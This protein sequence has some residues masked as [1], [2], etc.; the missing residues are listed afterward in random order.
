M[1]PEGRLAYQERELLK[2][3]ISFRG[4]RM[5]RSFHPTTIEVTTEDYLTENGD[6]IIGV[7]ASKGCS[8]LDPG[9]KAGLRTAGA[10]VTFRLIVGETNFEFFG[11]GDPRLGLSHPHDLVIRKSEFISDRTVAV[12]A[13]AAARD[14]PRT[15][16]KLLQNPEARGLMEIEI[17]G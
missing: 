6:C 2:D 1:E 11:R 13:N 5:V 9:V 16:V 10:K 7:G 14:I 3:V 4:H 17:S 8:Q 12:H 15:M